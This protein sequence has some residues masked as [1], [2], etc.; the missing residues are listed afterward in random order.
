MKGRNKQI[1]K[2]LIAESC[3]SVKRGERGEDDMIL[4]QQ[5]CLSFPSI[6]ER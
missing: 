1:N 6:L 2:G 3:E 4:E 5:N